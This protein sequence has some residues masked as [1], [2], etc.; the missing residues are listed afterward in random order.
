[1]E[2]RLQQEEFLQLV[3]GLLTSGSPVPAIVLLGE[4]E[5]RAGNYGIVGDEPMVE[6]GKAKE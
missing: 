2:D 4:I 3:K 6:V 1:M 5:K